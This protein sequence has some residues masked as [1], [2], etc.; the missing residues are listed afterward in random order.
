[1]NEFSLL[2][3]LC[4]AESRYIYEC[5]VC[6]RKSEKIAEKE[7][8]GARAKILLGIIHGVNERVSIFG[9]IYDPS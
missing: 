5:S 2:L 9:R 1:M 6:A 8:E 3:P 7:L 4:P